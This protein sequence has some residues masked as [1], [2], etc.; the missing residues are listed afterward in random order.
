MTLF[1]FSSFSQARPPAHADAPFPVGTHSRPE[2][3]GFLAFLGNMG[4]MARRSGTCRSR[5]GRHRGGLMRATRWL[6]AA[7]LLVV[8]AGLVAWRHADSAPRARTVAVGTFTGVAV[9]AQTGRAFVDNDDAS[10]VTILASPGGRVLHTVAT[11]ADPDG[12]A[13]DVRRARVFVADR[14][15]NALGSGASVM[16]GPP[17][18]SGYVAVLDARSGRVLSTIPVGADPDAVAVDQQ[19]GAV[20]VI[21]ADTSVSILDVRHRTVLSTTVLSS[22]LR[23]LAVAARPPR[24]FV[25]NALGGPVGVFDA[26]GGAL[27]RPVAGGPR[28]AAIAVDEHV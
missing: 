26:R 25:G 20:F 9:D 2:G 17:A 28:P 15:R 4:V 16:S 24:V 10:G 12:V 14:D 13:V 11:G 27:G 7:L 23:A 22:D 19:S 6:G 8:L 5:V 3:R 18:R 1:I 21:T